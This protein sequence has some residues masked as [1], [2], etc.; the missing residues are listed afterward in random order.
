MPI[1]VFSKAV[2]IELAAG[3]E[4]ASAWFKI[5]LKKEDSHNQF[6]LYYLKNSIWGYVR[7]EV[8]IVVR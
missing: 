5:V 4:S 7:L 2:V 6:V 3:T 8:F 1:E